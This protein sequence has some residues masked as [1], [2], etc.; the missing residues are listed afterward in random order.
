MFEDGLHNIVDI[1]RINRT[2]SSGNRN[3]LPNVKVSDTPDMLNVP[4]RII[5]DEKVIFADEIILNDGDTIQDLETGVI[6]EIRK[7]DNNLYRIKGLKN[8]VHH[9]S[10]SIRIKVESGKQ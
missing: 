4:C 10:Y 6:Y 8:K 5:K 1:Y 7:K 9:S 3:H 2:T